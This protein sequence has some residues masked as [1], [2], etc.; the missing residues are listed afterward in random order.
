[1]RRVGSIYNRDL[2]KSKDKTNDKLTR[3]SLKTRH[4]QQEANYLHK[5]WRMEYESEEDSAEKSSIEECNG[6]RYETEEAHIS[7]N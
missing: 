5:Q 6:R 2:S 4:I 3:G 7:F 1:M